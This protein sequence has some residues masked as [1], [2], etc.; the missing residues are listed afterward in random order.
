MSQFDAGAEP[1]WR[2][3]NKTAT[4][5]PFKVLPCNVDLNLKNK[6][7]NKLS[8]LSEQFDFDQEDLVPDARFNEVLW[9]AVYGENSICP[10]PVHAAFFNGTK[11]TDGD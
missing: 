6:A 1:L 5:P 11:G 8:E 4:H 2:C 3:F 9:G 7:S 10:P